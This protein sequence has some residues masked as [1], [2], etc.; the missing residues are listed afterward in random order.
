M[1]IAL[2]MH[3]LDGV[4]DTAVTQGSKITHNPPSMKMPI[5]I[6]LSARRI[7]SLQMEGIGM[8]NYATRVNYEFIMGD[9]GLLTNDK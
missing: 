3:T 5:S 9:A 2:A 6:A 4:S 1:R 8:S 7:C